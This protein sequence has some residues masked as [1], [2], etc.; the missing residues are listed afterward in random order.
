MSKRISRCIERILSI[1]LLISII[2]LSVL[3]ILTFAG[4]IARYFFRSPIIW[5]EE[6]QT[7]MMLWTILSGS[8]YAFRKGAHVSIDILTENFSPLWQKI[9]AWFGYLCTMAA[10]AFFFYFSLR[11][12]IQFYKTGKITTTLRI[13]SWKIN[14]MVSLGSLWMALSASYYFIRSQFSMGSDEKG[15]EEQ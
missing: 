4:A 6:V 5:M 7:W 15:E 12:N 2:C 10:L 3:V 8:S 11:L 9:V 14:C 13:P 1:D